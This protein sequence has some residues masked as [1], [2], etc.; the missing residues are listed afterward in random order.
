MR[1][2][3]CNSE[4]AEKAVVCGTCGRALVLKH[5]F[6]GGLVGQRRAATEEWQ[7]HAQIPG[8]MK[9]DYLHATTDPTQKRL[10][11][12]QGLL[13]HMRTPGTKLDDL[14][15]EA[16]AFISRQFGIDGVAIGLKDPKDGLY[17]YR[18]MA[19]FR[20]DAMESLKRIA[21]RKEQFYAD[22]HFVGTDI[23]KLSRIYLAE[24]NVLTNDE[25]KTFN[26]PGLLAMKRRTVTDS[27]EG[28]YI[29]TKILG[30]LDDLV[31]WIE[32][33][34][35]RTMK[36]PDAVTI[37]WVETVASIIGTAI[38]CQSVHER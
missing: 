37:R 9:L 15:Q 32:I 25:E 26:R 34:G 38:I 35:T 3:A 29:D 12:L 6:V 18:A 8:K 7:D 22:S 28:D 36:L 1:C 4:N 5:D 21:Y 11:G 10:E 2:P 20:E 19:G 13:A 31:G 24:D 17:R 23:S 14:L 16:A 33:S 27:L 30:H